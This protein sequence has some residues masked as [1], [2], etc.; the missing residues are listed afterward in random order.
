MPDNTVLCIRFEL[1]DDATPVLIPQLLYSL[2]R[3][4]WVV[5]FECSMDQRLH[6]LA[7]KWDRLI[8]SFRYNVKIHIT[9]VY[10]WTT[11]RISI[12][13]RWKFRIVNAIQII[14]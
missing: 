7:L 10:N 13:G 3:H 6:G 1:K 9:Y 8:E 14:R 4:Q 11:E 5:Q 12:S 2:I